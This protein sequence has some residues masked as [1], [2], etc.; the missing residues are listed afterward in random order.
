[1]TTN[2]NTMQSIKDLPQDIKD[3]FI[4]LL[5]QDA[6]CFNKMNIHPELS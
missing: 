3:D 1:M 6:Q 4:E 5:A 2:K